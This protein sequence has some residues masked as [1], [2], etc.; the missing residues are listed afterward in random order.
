MN[1][2]RILDRMMPKRPRVNNWYVMDGRLRG[3]AYGIPALAPGS[4]FI[5]SPILKLDEQKMICVTEYRTYE[6]GTKY[7]GDPSTAEILHQ[8]YHTWLNSLKSS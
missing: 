8:D 2:E 3:D 7:E 5:S 4:R 1:K 6:L